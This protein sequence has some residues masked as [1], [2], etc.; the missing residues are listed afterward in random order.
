[1]TEYAKSK[2]LIGFTA[3]ILEENKKM[4]NLINQSGKVTMKQ[5][6]DEYHVT[7]LF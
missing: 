7:V 4:I 3:Y 1:M 2:G 6:M 5:V